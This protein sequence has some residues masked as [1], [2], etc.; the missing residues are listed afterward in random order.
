[1]LKKFKLKPIKLV[2]NGKTINLT[3][4]NINIDSN[5]FSVD[6]EGNMTCSN[7][8]I[9][10]GELNLGAQVGDIL[11]KTYVP[12]TNISTEIA[13][14]G[15]IVHSNNE[16]D[17]MV[18]IGYLSSTD[19][20][21]CGSI[22][23]VNSNVTSETNIDAYGILTPTLIQTS[24]AKNKKNFEKLENA[25]NILQT[26]DIYKYNLK[27]EKDTDKKHIGFVIGDNFNYSKEVTSLD[28]QGVD[29]YSFTSLCCKA[30][31]EL[32]TKVEELK[33]EIEKLKGEKNG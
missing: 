20:D 3:G 33:K 2:L 32:S 10:G 1:M 19:G 28:N 22:R 7:A 27:N 23:L 8:N 29:N 15:L 13:P 9:T 5:N 18:D 16:T 12:G 25:L 24:L 17:Y 21:E 4:D 30:I 11:F 6:G 14:N 31:Q 26:I